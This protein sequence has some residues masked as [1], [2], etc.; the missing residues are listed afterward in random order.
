MYLICSVHGGGRNGRESKERTRSGGMI[1][2][3]C[4]RNSPATAREPDLLKLEVILVV[5]EAQL[6]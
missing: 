3:K 6:D 4:R 5:E 1:S 2:G